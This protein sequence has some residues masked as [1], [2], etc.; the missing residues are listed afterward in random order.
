MTIRVRRPNLPPT[1]IRD[2][3]ISLLL[4]DLGIELIP[5]SA[6]GHDE[7]RVGWVGFYLLAEPADVRINHAAITEVCVPPDIG[8]QAIAAQHSAV[9]LCEFAEE[10]KLRPG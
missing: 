10:E 3:S 1:L 8:E 6:D 9:L 2:P 7:R 5:E 4:L